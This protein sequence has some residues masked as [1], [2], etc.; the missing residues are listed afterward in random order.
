MDA[1]DDIEE[2]YILFPPQ[3]LKF[4]DLSFLYQAEAMLWMHG[5]FIIL[6][7]FYKLSQCR[8]D[9][10]FNLKMSAGICL[11]SC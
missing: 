3:L 5:L 11:I 2:F 1:Y 8:L 7:E 9:L 4:D 10:T 6:C